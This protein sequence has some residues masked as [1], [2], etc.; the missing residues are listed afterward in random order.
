MFIWPSK[1]KDTDT[2]AFSRAEA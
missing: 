1:Q 2:Y